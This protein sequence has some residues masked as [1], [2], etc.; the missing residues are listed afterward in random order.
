M[1][2]EQFAN[3]LR[4][5]LWAVKRQTGKRIRDIQDEIGYALG[6]NGGSWIEWLRKGN[7]PPTLRDSEQIAQL[8]IDESDLGEEWCREL[9]ISSGHPYPDSAIAALFGD[10]NSNNPL[11]DLFLFCHVDDL[12]AAEELAEHLR[13]ANLHVY[14]DR[15][16]LQPEAPWQAVIET[17]LSH[18]RACVLLFGRQSS[19]PW[20]HDQLRV[21]LMRLHQLNS[22]Q[23]I[24]LLLPG[25]IRCE[26]GRLPDSIREIPWIVFQHEISELEPL[27]RL[28]SCMRGEPI[29]K[30]LDDTLCPY[31]GLLAFEEKHVDFFFG[32]AAAIQWLVE[33]LQTSRFCAVI[34]PSGS[35]KSSIVRAGL[36]PAVKAGALG[37]TI[38][39][40]CRL[41]LPG[42]RPL[43]ELA[44]LLHNLTGKPRTILTVSDWIVA[45]RADETQFHHAVRD[46]CDVQPQ[47][48]R[49]LLVIDQFEELFVLC[50]DPSDREAF[51]ANLLFASS[52]ERGYLT[53]VLTMR[54]D[55]YH[56]CAGHSHLAARITEHQL[57]VG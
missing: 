3:L 38:N 54:A 41:I 33:E 55:F 19:G 26:R 51:L 27:R 43:E 31:R 37:N 25:G 10:L 4:T 15:W 30:H 46:F 11:Y 47:P 28:I 52:V 49:L 40:H 18:C 32:R 36:V 9:L 57:L 44:H 39:Y 34:G 23:V 16:H 56:R 53:L 29:E 50:S 45:L 1:D 24:P 20:E 7:L 6:R 42:A 21:T 13:Q 17:T 14:L 48:T 35:G 8:I 5:G 2:P 22:L 12:P